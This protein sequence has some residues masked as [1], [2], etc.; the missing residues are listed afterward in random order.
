MIE[1]ITSSAQQDP[2]INQ[3]QNAGLPQ[4][5]ANAIRS[6]AARTGVDFAYLL[7][8]ASQESS[9]NPNAKASTSSAT[10]L[11]QFTSQTWL[12]MIKTH[13]ADYGLSTYASHITTDN[14]GVAHVDSPAWRKAILDMRKD[15][16]ISAEMAGELDKA[17][18][19]TLKAN[20]GGKI[21]GTD[22]YLA[23]FLGAGGATQF[24]KAM[25]ANPHAS[26][27][28]IV[29]DAAASNTNVFYTADGQ[30][31]SLSQIYKHFAQKFDAT[32][33]NVMVASA[34]PAA[35]APLMSAAPM[36]VASATQ[37][38]NLSSFM[39]MASAAPLS[40]P[41]GKFTPTIAND[42]KSSTMSGYAAMAIAQTTLDHMNS[43]SAYNA[44]VKAYGKKNAENTTGLA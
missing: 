25:R 19:N 42:I 2:A 5:I 10:G 23:H 18:L 39:T 34:A 32:P 33:S 43:L 21:G 16:T 4:G 35:A 44:M 7:N 31:K 9:F 30:A 24:I 17:N 40:S 27:A 37:A 14:N 12:Q 1:A 26:A 41:V 11:Y 3:A 28:D 20:V 29:P 22:L 38:P 15:P 13:G 8:K 6:A 36:A